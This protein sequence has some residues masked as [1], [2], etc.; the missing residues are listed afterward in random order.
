MMSCAKSIIK[1]AQ[2]YNLPLVIDGVCIP[3]SE[4]EAMTGWNLSRV[5]RSLNY[6]RIL[7]GSFDS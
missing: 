7:H 6:K 2:E 5:N 1:K 4:I 3:S